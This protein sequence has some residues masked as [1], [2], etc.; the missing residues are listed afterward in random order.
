MDRTLFVILMASVCTFSLRAFPFVIFRNQ[1]QKFWKALLPL[2]R[3]A[4]HT[5]HSGMSAENAPG[6][7]LGS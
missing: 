1:A 4:M 5:N 2:Y 7:A 3:M 6:L